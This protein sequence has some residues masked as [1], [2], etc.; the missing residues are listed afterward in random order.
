MALAGARGASVRSAGCEALCAE[1]TV[2]SPH[3]PDRRGREASSTTVGLTWTS[4]L[5]KIHSSKRQS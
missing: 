1:Q 2:V 3:P 4:T 5:T